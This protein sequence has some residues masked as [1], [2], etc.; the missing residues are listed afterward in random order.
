MAESLIETAKKRYKLCEEY[1]RDEY[2]RGDEDVQF[3][4]GENQWPD[5]IKEQREKD[6]QPCLTENRTLVFVNQVANNIRQLRPSIDV[7][8]VDDNAD[9]EMAKILKGLIRNI[10][11]QS[12]ADSAYDMM[13]WNAITA[14]YGWVRVNTKYCDDESF[15]QECEIVR[16]PDF[17]SVMIDPN[18]I[19]MDGAD[20]EYAFI[21]EDMDIDQFREE[22]PDAAEENFETDGDWVTDEKIRICEYFYKKYEKKTIVLTP[23]GVMSKE[24]ADMLGLEIRQKRTLSVPSVKISKITGKEELESTDWL[25]KY[26]PI[27]ACY[28]MEAWIKRKR[29]C[30]SL[31]NQAKDPQRRFNYWLSA[32]T[33]VIALQPKAPFIGLT[34]QFE[35]D[36]AKWD[37]ANQKAYPYIQFDPIELDSGQEYANSPQ[38][39][40]PPQGS[41]A[42]FQEMMAAADGIKAVIGLFDASL[43]N[44][45]NETSGRAI[46][47][48]QQNSD[49]ATFNFPDNLQK[50]IAHVG[51]IL[52]DLI[53]KVYDGK[54]IVRIIG[55]DDAKMFAPLN[56]PVVKIKGGYRPMTKDDRKQDAFFRTDLGKYDVIPSTG[57]NF[58]TKRLEMVD[59]FKT[60]FQSAPQ[61]F[62]VFGDIFCKSLDVPENDLMAERLRRMYPVMQDEE[63]P[64]HATLQQAQ[65]M[66]NDMQGQLEKMQLALDS[67]VEKE[68]A[69]MQL[70]FEELKIKNKEADIK[71]AETAAKIEQ[72]RAE[73]EGMSKDVFSDLVRT[74]ANLEISIKDTA[75]AVDMIL[76][77]EE[78]K[79]TVEPKESAVKGV[80]NE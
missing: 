31:I 8:P 17:R 65:K 50:S 54:R 24:D 64:V 16:I 36:K 35:T 74:I 53:P 77:N 40:P 15:D 45:A 42:M 20:A 70:K 71:A 66:V 58:A 5:D 10:Q 60:L 33:S 52:I 21:T 72:M 2:D 59:L 80:T 51:R 38:R 78:A 49:N 7:L 28:G 56:Q 48:R 46:A 23:E 43:G 44:I 57:T 55:D 12:D 79:A 4:F 32:S 61:T 19:R 67:K 27:S 39:Q 75:E 11:T 3:V 29:K 62:E 13:G 69:E 6:G 25:G 34:G 68:N 73:T 41:P 47:Q 63:D 1:Y 18:S 9:V 30:F 37:T 76:S 26:I 22:Y 14:A